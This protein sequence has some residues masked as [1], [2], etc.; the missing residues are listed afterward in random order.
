MSC[1]GSAFSCGHGPSSAIAAKGLG[2]GVIGPLII[3]ELCIHH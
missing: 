1:H 3:I 2:G